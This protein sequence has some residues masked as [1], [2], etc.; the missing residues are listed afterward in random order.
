M[1]TARYTANKTRQDGKSQI[2][3]KVGNN[4]MRWLALAVRGRLLS[5]VTRAN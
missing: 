1:N 5:K 3:L 2:V 4:T